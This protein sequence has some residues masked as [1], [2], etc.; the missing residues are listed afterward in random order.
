MAP[1]GTRPEKPFLE[2]APCLIAV[3]VQRWGVQPDATKTKHY[4]PTVSVAIATGMLITAIHHAG[5]VSLPYTPT[6]MQFLSG[7]LGRPENERPLM[8]LVVGYPAAGATVPELG[9]KSLDE[10][11]M[12]V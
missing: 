1:L 2:T 12:F 11:A 10:I 6:P 9:K 5:L 3:F 4:F 8:I 7:I